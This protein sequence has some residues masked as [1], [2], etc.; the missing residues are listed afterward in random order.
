V[1]FFKLKFDCKIYGSDLAE[2]NL[3]RFLIGFYGPSTDRLPTSAGYRSTGLRIC[4]S[5]GTTYDYQ[6]Y[7]FTTNN[8][9]VYRL[10]NKFLVL[11]MSTY[12]VEWN[13]DKWVV[14]NS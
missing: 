7:T 14:S 11:L 12:Y 2:N 4:R 6:V 1:V 3:K 10:C 13:K 8:C 5:T 9:H